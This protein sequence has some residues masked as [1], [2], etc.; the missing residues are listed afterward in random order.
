MKDLKYDARINKA[1]WIR[2]YENVLYEGWREHGPQ[3]R[4]LCEDKRQAAL[5]AK[6]KAEAE[7]L[8]TSKKFLGALDALMP[9]GKTRSLGMSSSNSGANLSIR[10]FGSIATEMQVVKTRSQSQGDVL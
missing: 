5:A 1:H 3:S 10:K 8:R 7:R 4:K 9:V 6:R 2:V